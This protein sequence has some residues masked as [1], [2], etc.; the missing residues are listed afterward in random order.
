MSCWWLTGR[1]Q[2]GYALHLAATLSS[3]FKGRT[4]KVIPHKYRIRT[5][6]YKSFILLA[7]VRH[8]IGEQYPVLTSQHINDLYPEA[9]VML[10]SGWEPRA[11]PDA[12]TAY[13]RLY[14]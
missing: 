5:L 12:V 2:E 10:S 11:Y 8:L 4:W 1:I 9:V 14:S 3:R 7:A 6:G 13:K